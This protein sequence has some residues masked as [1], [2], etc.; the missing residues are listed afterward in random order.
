M[1]STRN[2]FGQRQ[3]ADTEA[4]AP[5]SFEPR[6]LESELAAAEAEVESAR[7]RQSELYA[8]AENSRAHLA[9]VT[10]GVRTGKSMSVDGEDAFSSE[11]FQRAKARAEFAELQVESGV[12]RLHDAEMAAR[13]IRGELLGAEVKM[14]LPQ[15]DTDI[16]NSIGRAA[17]ALADVLKVR[18]SR[19]RYVVN[20]RRRAESLRSP[21]NSV[22]QFH[23]TGVMRLT[24]AGTRV[25]QRNVAGEVGSRLGQL[26]SD[27]ERPLFGRGIK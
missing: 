23:P 20:V 8:A 9:F 19:E 4:A 1:L 26:V 5:Q 24:I 25:A 10:A 3:P 13:R 17:Q 7:Q 12:Q 22:V 27:L 18:D 14:H 2:I 6:D 16:D 15:L 11:A 21:D